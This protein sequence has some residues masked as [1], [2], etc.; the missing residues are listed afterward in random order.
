MNRYLLT[1]TAVMAI[2][3]TTISCDKLLTTAPEAGD[4]F[5]TPFDPLPNE[6]NIMF[7]AGDEAFDHAFTA[8]EGLGPI[9]NNVACAACHSADGRGT[10]SEALVRFSRGSD[11]IPDEGGPQHQD[12][13]IPGVPLEQIPSDAQTSVRMPPAVFGVGLMEAISDST[14]LSNE[15]PTD[16]DG[17]GISG[18]VNWVTAGDFVPTAFV[19]GGGGLQVGRFGLK[20]NVSS[21]LEQVV[22]AYHQ[23]M[24]I[25]SDFIPV[26]NNHQDGEGIALG[27]LAPD[28][29][30]SA[31][32]VL[33]VVVYV[34]LLSPP[35]RGEITPEVTLG[36][37]LFEGIGC[38]SCHIPSMKTGVHN[39]PQLNQ[40]DANLYSDLLLHDMGNDLA[41][42]RPDGSAD[43]FEWRTTPLWG[44]RIVPD[45]LDGNAF[46]LHDG[47][48][49]TLE[50]AIE[51][52]G[53]EAQAASDA[54]SA[55][56]QDDKDALIAFLESL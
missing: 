33:D 45:F 17:D 50:D 41:D 10:P 40:V 38:V 52:H 22:N 25:T 51:F 19:G 4:D 35:A 23:D 36:E 14:I 1:I 27:D 9:F 16:A 53:G 30:I 13:A 29:E 49:T 12:K 42:F 46:Y 44:L 5:E 20:A 2:L 56:S 55:L 31:Q 6:L 32:T 15:D 39:V 21:L 37:S 11:L 26:E 48:A 47:R 8:S 7:A 18:R 24:G 28:P 43:G 3:I 34:R 54:F